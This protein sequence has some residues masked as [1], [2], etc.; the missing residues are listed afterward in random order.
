MKQKHETETEI[1]NKLKIGSHSP[2]MQ[3]FWWC[4]NMVLKNNGK[5]HFVLVWLLKIM[6]Y[7]SIVEVTASIYLVPKE[8]WNYVSYSNILMITNVNTNETDIII[9]EQCKHH[10]D[11]IHR[12]FL[13][14]F[15]LG[16][17]VLAAFLNSDWLR[18]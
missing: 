7:W 8:H 9:N 2:C 16:M 18:R 4:T 14:Y 12:T 13:S 15:Q 11:Q 10:N 6:K 1:R 3:P 17:V 5:S